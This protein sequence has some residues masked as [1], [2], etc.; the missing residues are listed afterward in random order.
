MAERFQGNPIDDEWD[1]GE[2]DRFF[3]PTFDPKDSRWGETRTTKKPLSR[4]QILGA[5]T[6]DIIQEV[7]T[8]IG[9]HR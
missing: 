7:A 5:K 4:A 2:Y 9:I 3:N 1:S 6:M 8:K